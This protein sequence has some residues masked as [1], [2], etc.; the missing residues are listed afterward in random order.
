MTTTLKWIDTIAAVSTAA[1]PSAIGVI[2]ISGYRVTSICSQILSRNNIPIS[3]EWMRSHPRF[4]TYCELASRFEKIDQILFTFYAAPNSFTGEDMGELS[5]HGNP[6]L[7]KK[8]LELIFSLGARP[9]EKGEFSKRAYTNEK[10]DISSALAISQVISARSRFELEL[11]QKNMFGE[12]HRLESRL[13][14]ELINIKAEC[15]AEI[16]FST[17]DLTFESFEER[18]NKIKTVTEICK[19][20]IKG[21]DRAQNIIQ[22]SKIVIYGDPNT[23]KS[24]L[25]NLILGRERAIVSHIPGTTRDFLSEDLHLEGLPIQLVD[26]AGVRD[27]SDPIEKLGIERSEKEFSTANVRILVID[28]S[29]PYEN[30]SFEN[31]YSD[32]LERTIVLGNKYDIIHSSWDLNSL[33]E[34]LH[35]KNSSFVKCSCKLKT[36]VDELIREI[37]LHISKEDSMED[38]ILLED[39]NLYL[40]KKILDSLE[41]AERLMEENAPAEVYVREIDFA[42]EHIGQINGRI[43]TEEIL[44]RIFS[45]FCVGK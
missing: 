24:S 22:K 39:R 16:D 37:H 28:L 14:S 13:R 15:E 30:K 4:S 5:L 41:N 10:L 7:I 19:K 31:K 45:K 32:K 26:T 3:E 33:Q 1:L 21:N 34:Y 35:Q 42:L 27:T 43:D 17:E 18:K 9:A 6:I 44:G 8:A 40:L 20:V 11:A 2:R 36:G 23:G 12:M 29:I 38:M 25:M